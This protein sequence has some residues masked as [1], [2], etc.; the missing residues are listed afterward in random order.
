MGSPLS[1]ALAILNCA[2]HEHLFHK[3]LESNHRAI[4]PD[5]FSVRYIDDLCR[6]SWILTVILNM[7]IATST[8][9]DPA[10]RFIQF[11][12]IFF[13]STTSDSQWK[14]NRIRAHSNSLNL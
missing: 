9:T 10:L 5:F 7:L 13:I 8:L 4:A 11:S 1:P 14:S 2:Y 3:F 6:L 12:M